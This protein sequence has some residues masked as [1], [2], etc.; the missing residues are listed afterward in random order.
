MVMGMIAIYAAE[1][2]VRTRLSNYPEPFAAR[3]KGREKRAL[4]DAFGLT[5]F[6]VNLTRLAPGAISALHHA[7]S[8][9]DELVYV[10]LGTPILYLGRERAQLA[11]G[12]CAGFRGGTGIAHHLANESSEWVEYLEIGDRAAGDQ[13]TYPDDDLRARKVDGHWRFEHKDGTPY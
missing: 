10:L 7:H 6:G 11:P 8:V 5:Q 13:G 4:G 1:V 2:A 9:Q 3:M 12:M